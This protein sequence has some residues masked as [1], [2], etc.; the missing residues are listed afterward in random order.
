MLRAAVVS[1]TAAR[2][3]CSIYSSTAAAAAAP[4][5]L[6]ELTRAS[7]C[8][9][10]SPSRRASGWTA[11]ARASPSSAALA[12]WHHYSSLRTVHDAQPVRR[13]ATQ[14]AKI[15]ASAAASSAPT[16]GALHESTA[17][18]AGYPYAPSNR[19]EPPRTLLSKRF[20]EKFKDVK[21]P[22]GYNGLG[23]M[24]YRRTY[25]R[26][27]P[28]GSNETW[29]ETV[30]RVVEGTFNMQY[31]WCS[32]RRLPWRHGL[33]QKRAEDMYERMFHMKFLP[34]GRGLWAMGS[35]LTE[36]RELF[37]AL[38][39]CAFVST[40]CMHD[41]ELK[42]SKPFAFLMDMSMLGV[43]VGFDTKGAEPAPNSRKKAEGVFVKGVNLS[44]K[45]E[46]IQIA[47]SREG[48]VESV[49]ALIDSYFDGTNPVQFDYSKIRGPG[50]PI[51]GFGGHSSG[52][53]ALQE[54]HIGLRDVL[55][56]CSGQ[57]ITLTAIVDMMNLIGKCVVS[58]NVR[59]TAEIAFGPATSEEYLDLKNHAVN[60]QRAAFSWTSN[61]SIFADLGMDYGPACK[62]IVDNG[63]PGFAWLDNMRQFSRM[64]NLPDGKD[65]RASG[66]NPCLEQTL[67]SFEL[68]CLVETFPHNHSSLEDFLATLDA[69]YLYAKT[70]TL[71]Q[72]H[73][74]ESNRVLLRNR[75]IGC[76]MSGIALQLQKIGIH[77][78][79]DWCTKGYERIQ[80]LDREF[81][82]EFAIPRS[83]KT[84]SVKP[85]GTV[86]LLAG[87]TP[88][89]HYPESRYCRRRVRVSAQSDLLPPLIKAGY[90]VEPDVHSSKTMIVS[91]PVDVG[92]DLRAA[93]EVSMWE[94]LS[95]AS[96]LQRHW[97]D[98][99]VRVTVVLTVK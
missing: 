2:T 31:R 8:L 80:E 95:L 82:D 5:A 63:E 35:P 24:V 30:Q 81:S 66:G 64:L 25:S 85:S 17:E 41:P 75:R 70:V 18:F 98:N 37:A 83:I 71:G 68:C 58:G 91:F 47:D 40:E 86:S 11:A 49:V 88:G 56:R 48:W 6:L 87:A 52:P 74:P 44:K 29:A 51:K 93:S 76:S 84:T 73:W 23:E 4:T 39:N 12:S 77:Q 1:A 69:A 21:P 60:P 42:R 55:D 94:Q 38:N 50:Q 61:N 32:N 92:E 10:A 3:A 67:E 65:H 96:F 27:K 9:S 43:G 62:R 78:F 79:R 13:L 46:T 26:K 97:A 28:D 90:H 57:A 16:A 36:E 72:T 20:L 34:P 33:A 22:F 15:S 99:Q 59:Q 14:I 89:M 7:P 54:L 53:G 19:R 45:V